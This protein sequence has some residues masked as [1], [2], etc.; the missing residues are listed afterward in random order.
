MPPANIDDL[1]PSLREDF[2]AVSGRKWNHF[3]CPI[4]QVDE[5][6]ELCKAHVINASF[7]NSNRAVTVQRKDVDNFFGTHFERDFKLIEFA[8]DAGRSLSLEAL[9]D[10]DLARIVQPKISADGEDQDFYVTTNPSGIP[11]DHTEVRLGS[12]D[13]QITLVIKS[14]PEDVIKKISGPWEIRAEKDLRLSV[15]VS[16][17]KAAHLTLFHRLGYGYALS[18]GGRFMGQHVLGSFFLRARDHDRQSVQCM[19]A[20]H[21]AEFSTLVRPAF[22]IAGDFNGTLDDGFGWLCMLGRLPWAINVVVRVDDRFFCALVPIMD[23]DDSVHH[24]L[25]FLAKPYGQISVAGALFGQSAIETD[26]A[27][28]KFDWP[29][30]RFTG[31]PV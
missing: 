13:Q 16:V 11:K 7:P 8:P 25:Q 28:M 21:F 14:S 4:L 12:S 6:A 9:N 26:F 29:E 5:D 24:F 10:R 27:I 23:T 18:V 17:L 19:A 1:L 31:K 2:N 22:K 3:H 30:G 20:E 15:L